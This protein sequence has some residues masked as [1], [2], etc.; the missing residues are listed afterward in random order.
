MI[1]LLSAQRLNHF[2]FLPFFAEAISRLYETQINESVKKLPV[3]H[4]EALKSH[5][6]IRNCYFAGRKDKYIATDILKS[7]ARA[8]SCVHTARPRVDRQPRGK[9]GLMGIMQ[10]KPAVCCIGRLLITLF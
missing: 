1:V 6:V 8:C 7:C 4:R 10:M 9:R 5:D 2:I 3:S